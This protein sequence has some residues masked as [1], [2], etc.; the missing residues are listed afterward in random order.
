MNIKQGLPCHNSNYSAKRGGNPIKYV[1][2]HYT[3]NNG[4]TAQ[5]NCKYFNSPNRKASA[6]YFVG[7]D[8][9][10]QS[11]QDI[12]TAWH[13]GGS[14]YKHKYC[15]NA[16]S[17]GVEMCSKIDGNG[18]Y[19]IE[20][21]VID[22]AIDLTKYLMD[23]YNILSSN[24]VRHYDVTGKAC[25]EPFVRDE[26]IWKNFKLQLEGDTMTN[27][28][29]TKF[30]E[31]VDAVSAVTSDVDELKKPKM[32]YNYIDNN[33]PKWAR[34]T[35]QKLVDKGILQGD[36]NGLGLTDDLLRVLVINDRAGLYD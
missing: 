13:C 16:N 7:S 1:V 10:F 28:E 36:E 27:E 15:R 3:A 12:H 29:R 8:G 5:N 24:V 20:N 14:S 21:S 22:N 2:I 19:Y 25:P 18:K 33:M 23:K 34:P 6:H 9:V 11:V 32:I 31:L 30:N 4:D 26:N 17:I 35:I